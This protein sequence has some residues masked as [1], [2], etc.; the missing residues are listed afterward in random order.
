MRKNK[1]T[2]I[3]GMGRSGT[4]FLS[5]LLQLDSNYMVK[6]EEIG[7]REFLLASWYIGQA[8]TTPYLKGEKQRSYTH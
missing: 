5:Q 3:T 2:F 6:H 4:K 8:Y 1:Y 7:N